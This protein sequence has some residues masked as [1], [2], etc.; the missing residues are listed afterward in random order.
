VAEIY[1]VRTEGGLRQHR[2]HA[3]RSMR[4]AAIAAM[5]IVGGG[6]SPALVFVAV[7]LWL[8]YEGV[9][10]AREYAALRDVHLEPTT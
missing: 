6:R 3:I 2:R 10:A 8:F 4:R 9:R 7:F 1:P 5:R